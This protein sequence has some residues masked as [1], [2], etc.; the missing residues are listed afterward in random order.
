ME[1]YV[2]IKT[3]FKVHLLSVKTVT[4]YSSGTG[5]L[6]QILCNMTFIYLFIFSYKGKKK[7]PNCLQL[8]NKG[9]IDILLACY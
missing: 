4:E 5:V 9:F 1:S 7:K 6:Q 2:T 3:G 8:L